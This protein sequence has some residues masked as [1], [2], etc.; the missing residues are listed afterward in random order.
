[1]NTCHETMLATRGSIKNSA[2]V[3]LGTELKE[4]LGGQ[5]KWTEQMY[6]MDRFF[7]IRDE[8]ITASHH[9]DTNIPIDSSLPFKK[10]GIRCA[11]IL[12]DVN[13]TAVSLQKR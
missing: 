10:K 5:T 8:L 1:M 4:V 9:E 13:F 11:K 7:K 12:D 2:C 6:M 3:H